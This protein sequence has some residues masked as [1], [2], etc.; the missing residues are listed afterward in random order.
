MR[1]SSFTYSKKGSKACCGTVIADFVV[2]TSLIQQNSMLC[3]LSDRG[4]H[5]WVRWRAREVMMQLRETN[6]Q[7]A[8]PRWSRTKSTERQF[9]FFHKFYKKTHFKWTASNYTVITEI[10]YFQY[11]HFSFLFSFLF[12]FGKTWV[13]INALGWNPPIYIYI[14]SIVILNFWP[15]MVISHHQPKSKPRLP[16]NTGNGAQQRLRMM[17]NHSRCKI[18]LTYY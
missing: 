6:R 12:L 9:L 8:E 4:R 3:K 15:N 2:L 16:Q 10:L 5:L 17:V 7:T 14:M 1:T 18:N 11:T 13:K